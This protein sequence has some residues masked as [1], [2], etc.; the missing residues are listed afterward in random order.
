[1]STVPRRARD[2]P[3]GSLLEALRR[4]LRGLA[5]RAEAEP[6]LREALE[7]IIDEAN[8]D[9]R[10]EIT[11]EQRALLM[12][13]LSFGRL[14]VDDVMVPRADIKA[15]PVDAGLPEV[16]AAFQAAGHSRLV[17]YRDSLD[18]VLGYVHVKHLLPFWGDGAEFEL[19][20]LVRPAL[21]VPPSM[22]VI[23]LL[24]EMRESDGGIALVVDE[25][26]G[27]DGMVAIDDLIEEIVGELREERRRLELGELVQQPDG[28]IDVDGR[29]ELEELEQ[30]LGVQLLAPDERDEA[31][32]VAGLIY[33]L[34]DRVPACGDTV[35][36]PAGL[37]FEVLDAEPRR[38]KRVRVRRIDPGELAAAESGAA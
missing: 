8:E 31:D 13:A 25:F 10:S 29:F 4:R 21:V 37:S 28:A 16:V 7:E 3:G 33:S 38:V 27:I 35:I 12:N 15:V 30:R 5:G 23:D 2:E 32:T 11:A 22:P 26:G 19:E 20:R 1:V 36:H 34:A 9:G 18:D 14:G 24:I 17:V 6:D